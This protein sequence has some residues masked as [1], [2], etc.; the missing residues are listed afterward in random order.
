MVYAILGRAPG[1]LPSN[2]EVNPKERVKTITSRNGVQL[3]KI[4]VKR[5]ATSEEKVPSVDEKHVKQAEQT[6]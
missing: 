5:P 3:P 1:I 6:T 4:H 2:I